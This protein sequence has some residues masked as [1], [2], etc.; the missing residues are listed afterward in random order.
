MSARHLVTAYSSLRIV[1]AL[2]LL[3]APGRTARP[4]L[5]ASAATPGGT[6]AVRGLG[7]RDLLL[8]AGAIAASASGGSARPWLSACAASDAVDVAATLI[9]D[10]GGLPSRSKVGTVAAAGLFGAAGAA[11]AA[12]AS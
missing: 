2:G 10:G 5:G 1:Y 12:R 11:L 8:A 6:I 4:W 9:A 3:A 7:G